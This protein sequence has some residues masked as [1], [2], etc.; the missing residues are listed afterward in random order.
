MRI[1]DGRIAIPR[2]GWYAMRR[3]GGNPYPDG[4]P[5][6][7]VIKRELGKWYC[8]VCYE[9]DV[10]QRPDDG[11]IIGVDRNEDNIYTSDGTE[12]RVPDN[13][14]L[15]KLRK[16]V[17]YYQTLLSWHRYRGY[18]KNSC[19]YNQIKHRLAKKHAKIAYIM[20]TWRHH[21]SK[22]I[23]AT[24]STTAIEDLNVKKNDGQGRVAK[25]RLCRS[26]CGIARDARTQWPIKEE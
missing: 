14:A 24:A 9:V 5:K 11:K 22:Q 16:D 2:L 19:R 23:A 8:T 20:E 1:R 25:D 10:E 3:R 17:V 6:K 4:I 7:A 15:D 12:Y 26:Y 18:K 21:V 13:P